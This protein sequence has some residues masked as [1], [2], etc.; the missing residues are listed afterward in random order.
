MK[1]LNRQLTFPGLC[2]DP[3]IDLG[4]APSLP[5]GLLSFIGSTQLLGWVLF[6]ILLEKGSRDGIQNP[7][8]P[9]PRGIRPCVIKN[10]SIKCPALVFA[11]P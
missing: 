11:V 4:A 10:M 1:P 3:T 6:A 8:F 7:A 5:P 2:T 9:H